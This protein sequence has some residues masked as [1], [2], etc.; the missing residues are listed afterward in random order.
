MRTRASVA[1]IALVI[2][3]CNWS[4]GTEEES[5]P[6]TQSDD[7]FGDEVRC[8]APA[9]LSS[10]SERVIDVSTAGLARIAPVWSEDVELDEAHPY[11]RVA[12][13]SEDR[14]WI[15]HTAGNAIDVTT[16]NREGEVLEHGTIESPRDT[17]AAPRAV[18]AISERFGSPVLVVDW[19]RD[20]AEGGEYI[21]LGA[22]PREVQRR[23]E[24]SSPGY[25]WDCRWGENGDVHSISKTGAVE[26]RSD[27]AE[28]LWSQDG[29]LDESYSNISSILQGR[30]RVAVVTYDGEEPANTALYMLDARGNFIAAQSQLL[31]LF[32]VYRVFTWQDS[33]GYTI[34]WTETGG[35]RVIRRALD[36][37]TPRSVVLIREDYSDLIVGGCSADPTGNAYCLSRIGG[38]RDD[39][40][41]WIVCRVPTRGMP[42]SCVELE[43]TV[44]SYIDIAA[45]SDG[46][47][48]IVQ[49]GRLSRFDFPQ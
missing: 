39:Q 14:V 42:P 24:R 7:C 46:A 20:G 23:I 33:N 38:R 34:A 9:E 31:S 49:D 29:W 40:Q 10:G 3:G 17:G 16:R 11:L 47:L 48:M 27:T 19:H 12:S 37:G 35:D 1:L 43:G 30:D 32:S 13:D 5:K 2:C 4:V 44:T 22:G 36:T 15:V 8:D 28:L 25:G 41:T 18:F 6:R 26:H 21:K 45:L